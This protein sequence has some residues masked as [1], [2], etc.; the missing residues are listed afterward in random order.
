M[1]VD[2]Q[3]GARGELTSPEAVRA[4]AQCGSLSQRETVPRSQAVLP[5][6]KKTP[7][8]ASV[9][10]SGVADVKTRVTIAFSRAARCN[11]NSGLSS[12]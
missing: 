4:A 2:W 6:K 11:V 9:R 10:P 12:P 1:G 5:K 7:T 3:G 8:G